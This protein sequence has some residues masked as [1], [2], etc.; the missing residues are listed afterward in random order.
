MIASQF[1]GY[2][3]HEI[4]LNS[5]LKRLK[6]EVLSK[7]CSYAIE[8]WDEFK[9]SWESRNEFRLNCSEGS[10]SFEA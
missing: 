4:S 3:T 9:E 8:I 1:K 6:T 2:E 7:T 5:K 10:S